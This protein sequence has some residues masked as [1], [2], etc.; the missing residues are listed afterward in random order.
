MRL[1]SGV[2]LSLNTSGIAS[3]RCTSSYSSSSLSALGKKMTGNEEADLGR[4]SLQLQGLDSTSL[5]RHLETFLSDHAREVKKVLQPP[6]IG[7]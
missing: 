7:Q 2:E 1:T 5:L 3:S 6:Q 4:T